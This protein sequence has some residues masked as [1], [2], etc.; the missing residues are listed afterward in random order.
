MLAS[1]PRALAIGLAAVL[2]LLGAPAVPAI[3]APVSCDGV[4]VLVQPDQKDPSTAQLTCATSYDTGLA[5]LKSAGHATEFA[6]AMLNR[7]D[8]LPTDADFTSNGGYYWSYWSA[9]VNADGSLGEWAY[10]QVGPDTSKPQPG[11]AEGW[12]LTNDQKTTGPAL[13][14][15]PEG[16]D[17]ASPAPAGTS[18]APA[19]SAGSPTGL[20]VAAVVVVCALLGLGGWWLARGR[21]RP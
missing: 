9:P 14:A 16:A 2:V 11:T 10:Y 12:L 13:T 20:V 8:G 19:P 18:A 21:L 5:A 1:L 17:S 6:K 15:L 7:I 3:A 4:W